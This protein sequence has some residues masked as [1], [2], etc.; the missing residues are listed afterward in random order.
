[1]SQFE[2][3]TCQ[4]CKL[5]FSIAPEDFE[6]YEKVKVPPP[7]F[8]PECRFQRRIA[9][10]NERKL[11]R[12]KSAK[13]GKE[14]LALYPPES[15][16]TLYK[17]KEWWADDWD[18]VSYGRDYDFSRTFFEQFFELTKV[19]PRFNL[20][21]I[22]MVNSEY[23]ANASYLRNCYLMFN[24][25]KSEDCAYGNGVDNCKNCF[26]NSHIGRCERCYDSFW[27]ENCYQTHFSSQCEDCHGVWFS[28]NCKGCSDCFG[29]VNLRN[30]KYHIYN[31]PY[32]KEEYER[33]IKEMNLRS[34]SGL[35]AAKGDVSEFWKKFPNKYLQGIKNTN[36]TGE[37][38][39][40]SKNVRQSYLVREGENLKY[41]QYYQIPPNKDCYDVTVW[42]QNNQLGYENAVT[43]M[44]TFNV[45]FC[46]ESWTDIRDMEYCMYCNS[47]SNLFGCVG[48]RKKQ[49]CILN[50]EYSKEEYETLVEKIKKQMSEKPYTDK[51]GRI[52]KYGEFFPIELSP[53]GYN[54]TV[55]NEHFLLT[56]EQAEEEGYKWQEPSSREYE[57]TMKSEDI[58]DSINDVQDSIL[59]EIIQ[60]SDCKR[61][62]R[63]IK[64]ELDF[65][66]VEKISVPR[67]CV[68]CRHNMR[69]AQRNESKLYPRRCVCDYKIYK[70]TTKHSHHPE[71]RCPN[72]FETSYSTERKEIVYCEACY[73]NEVI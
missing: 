29:C 40:N 21:V 32:S 37:Y 66:R 14:I 3:R 27:L 38:V 7:T 1:M 33:K 36:V 46:V 16:V 68:D 23:C 6:F 17:E 52:Y 25:N 61:A 8:C 39:T 24:S 13:S 4:N 47:S 42:G 43:G 45:K 58:P 60:C 65:L 53:F 49:H 22:N 59:K 34:W 12:T 55:A 64:P 20:S 70:N 9:F 50:K 72:E 15:E 10:R 26:D 30:K 73:Q 18:A 48:L 67:T 2:Q 19:V 54:Q 51:K 41:V 57:I 35:T 31:T 71:G 11:F 56:K 28:K 5:T 63:L 44:G 69:V 62:Y